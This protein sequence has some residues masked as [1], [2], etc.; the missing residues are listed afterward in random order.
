MKKLLSTMALICLVSS[1]HAAKISWTTG[2][3]VGP[4][5][6]GGNIVGGAAYLFDTSVTG[7]SVAA[8]TAAIKDGTFES[9]GYADKAVFPEQTTVTPGAVMSMTD[10]EMDR[11][12]W[13]S[14]VEKTLFMVV[15]TADGSQ[16]KITD[17]LTRTMG[18]TTATFGFGTNIDGPGTSPLAVAAWQPV[19]EPATMALLGIGIVAVGL[20]RRRK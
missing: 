4:T 5:P 9:G 6:P 13:E 10:I 18:P 12:G 15:F 3:I 20:R 19:P 2:A 14:G 8:I 11:A 1:A 7:I 17:T 16:F